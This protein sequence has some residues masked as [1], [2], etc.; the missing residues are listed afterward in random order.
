MEWIAYKL[1]VK[2]SYE[3]PVAD[4]YFQLK[5]LPRTDETQKIAELTET[6]SATGLYGKKADQ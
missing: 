2:I 3:K 6:N 4:E 5:C 1:K